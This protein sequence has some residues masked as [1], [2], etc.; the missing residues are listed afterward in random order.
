MD[1]EPLSSIPSPSFHDKWWDTGQATASL[2]LSLSIYKRINHTE[3]ANFDH[4]S[5]NELKHVAVHL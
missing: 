3:P 2:S 4:Q 5:Q 1:T